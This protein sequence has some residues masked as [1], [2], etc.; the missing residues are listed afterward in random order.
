MTVQISVVLDPNEIGRRIAAARRRKGWTQ[1]D[2]ALQAHVSPSSISK[3]ERGRLPPV[4]QLI[5]LAEVME[6]DPGELVAEP[7]LTGEILA[8]LDE[9]LAE[10]REKPD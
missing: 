5:R 3:W 10:L 1:L 7:T 6:I 8:K 9:I 4:P 2:L